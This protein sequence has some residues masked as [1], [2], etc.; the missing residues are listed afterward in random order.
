MARR[1]RGPVLKSPP[2]DPQRNEVYR[3]ENTRFGC[4]FFWHSMP[5]AKAQKLAD[6]MAKEYGVKTVP[7]RYVTRSRNSWTAAQF[8]DRIEINKTRAR[9]TAPLVAHEMAHHIHDELGYGGPDHG[10]LWLGLYIRL[11]DHYKIM[12]GEGMAY[13]ARKAGL[14]LRNPNKCSPEDL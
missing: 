13:S 11:M 2:E 5:L 4:L 6:R 9:W 8:P 3:W 14:K 12:P 7:L 1:F 10:P